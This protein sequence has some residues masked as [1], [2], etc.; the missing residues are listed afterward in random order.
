MGCQSCGQRAAAAAKYPREV[1]MPDNTVVTVTSA[2]D[3]RVK[4]E[5]H[6]QLAREKAKAD[7][8]SVRR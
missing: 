1:T 6:R 8:Y 4:M 3:E 5:R 2:A 7:G